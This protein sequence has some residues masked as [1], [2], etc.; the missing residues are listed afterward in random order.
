MEQAN[1]VT[2]E[3]SVGACHGTHDVVL[4]HRAKQGATD[5]RVVERRMQV[6]EAHDANRASRLGRAHGNRRIAFQ[7][8]HLVGIRRLQPIHLAAP[9]RR[10]C[11]RGVV[12]GQPV[13]PLDVRHLWSRG[14]NRSP[15]LT[16][17]VFRETAV[18]SPLAHDEVS[19]L[20]P[21]RTTANHIGDRPRQITQSQALR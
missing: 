1:A 10:G 2:P 7:Q 18:G 4:P 14:V 3:A 21:E 6:V 5:R 8:R 19:S 16:R 12:D 9:Q 11:R 17:H 13:H 15:V 20:E